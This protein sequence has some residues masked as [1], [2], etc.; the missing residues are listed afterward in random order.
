MKS[1]TKAYQEEVARQ[2]R[3]ALV[4]EHLEYVRQ[5]CGTLAKRLPPSADIQNLQSAGVVGLIESA[6]SFEESRGVSFKTYSYPRIRGA[7]IDEI[8]RTSP[9]SQKAL[10]LVSRIRAELDRLE[11]PVTPEILATNL[12]IKVSEVEEGLI[13]MKVAYP[14]PWDETSCHAH[15][16]DHPES[17]LQYQEKL[18]MLADAIEQLP[19]RDRT[20]IQLYYLEELR[21]KEIGVVIGVSES[22]VSRILARAEL[23]LREAIRKHDTD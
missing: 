11:P 7:I 20:V 15:A 2:K 10:N 5:I 13:A 1:L 14:V 4:V 9:L 23:R 18:T 22:R 3:D 21:L 16:T 6:Q 19:E 17:R 8:R 12:G